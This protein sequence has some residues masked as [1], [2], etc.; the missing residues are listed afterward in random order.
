M[1]TTKYLLV[2]LAA[3]VI[4]CGD[5]TNG[6]GADGGDTTGTDG[7]TSNGDGGGGGGDGDGGTTTGDGGTVG[8]T[9]GGNSSVCGTTQCSNCIDDDDDGTIDGFDIECVSAAD[10][11]E[12]S[13]ATGIPGDNKDPH[14]DCFFDGDSGD[15]NDGC[16]I[17]DCC[18]TG[19]CSAGVDCTVSEECITKCGSVTPPGCD[20]FGCCTICEG[21][22]CRDVLINQGLSPDCDADVIDDTTLCP[23]CTKVEECSTT[24]DTTNCI[25]CPGQ[26][27]DDL[28]AE[29]MDQ[30]ACP[31]GQTTCDTG[32]DCA[33]DEY[34]SNGCC[35][36]GII[37]Q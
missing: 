18:L 12:G 37:I 21:D 28:P 26:T 15:G 31:D 1:R 30:N 25:L 8:G 13:F 24:C 34:C 35:L 10:D 32:S 7:S 19:D 17:E 3:L 5:N 23:T 36:E 27:E 4:G 6:S 11:D 29:C 2:L 20:C 14:Q 33:A 22:S 9:D 16:S